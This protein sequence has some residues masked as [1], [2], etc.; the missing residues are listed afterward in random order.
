MLR[1]IGSRREKSGERSRGLDVEPVLSGGLSF[2][3]S[4]IDFLLSRGD[5]FRRQSL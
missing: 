3:N 1:I 4:Y 2:P 5:L